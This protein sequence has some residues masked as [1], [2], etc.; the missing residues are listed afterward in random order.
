[1]DVSWRRD[2][3]FGR[4]KH[5]RNALFWG[6]KMKKILSRRIFLHGAGAVAAASAASPGSAKPALL[7]GAPVRTAPFPSWPRIGDNDRAAMVEVL[8]GGKWYRGSGNC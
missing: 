8:N 3:P 6:I 7:G 5:L 2:R 1:M 4:P